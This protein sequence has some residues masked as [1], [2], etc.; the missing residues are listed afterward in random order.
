MSSDEPKTIQPKGETLV[1]HCPL[2]GA[3]FE[4]AALTNRDQRCGICYPDSHR[5]FLVRVKTGE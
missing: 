5:D 1:K 2:C 4:T 3:Q